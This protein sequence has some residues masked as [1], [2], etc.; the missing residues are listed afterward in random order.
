MLR[1]W[2]NWRVESTVISLPCARRKDFVQ[3]SLRGLRFILKFLWLRQ[4]S[5]WYSSEGRAGEVY[6]HFDLQK[7]NARA[8]LRTN[9]IPLDGYTG[10]EQK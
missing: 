8:S 7:R 4:G 9:V 2:A 10:A 5:D 3:P 6:Y 1:R